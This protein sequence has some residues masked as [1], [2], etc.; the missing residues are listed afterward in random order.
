MVLEGRLELPRI[1]PLAPQASASA[2][3]PLEHI[4][5]TVFPVNA[6]YF[7][8]FFSF[9]KPKSEKKRK[10]LHFFSIFPFLRSFFSL[11]FPDRRRK[12][13]IAHR[14]DCRKYK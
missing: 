5:Q 2:I 1:A 14:H 13:G 10:I 12:S 11:F 6:I 7:T 3:P 9:V 4:A 8:P